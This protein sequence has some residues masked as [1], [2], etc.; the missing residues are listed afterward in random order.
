MNP[1][2]L[3]SMDDLHWCPTDKKFNTLKP[4]DYDKIIIAAKHSRHPEQFDDFEN[5][6]KVVRWVEQIKI[7]ELLIKGLLSGRLGI[8]LEEGTSAPEFYPNNE[9]EYDEYR[10]N[11][12]AIK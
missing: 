3:I 5:L 7:G 2:E 1:D 12:R 11:C 6:I 4:E 10:K 8:R 9:E